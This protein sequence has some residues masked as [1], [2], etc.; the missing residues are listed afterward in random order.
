MFV[1][2]LTMAGGY[3]FRGALVQVFGRIISP[4][5]GEDICDRF[6]PQFD[7]S[8]AYVSRNAGSSWQTAST[9]SD[10]CTFM[11]QMDDI[12]EDAPIKLAIALANEVYQVWEIWAD[13]TELVEETTIPF[14]FEISVSDSVPFWDQGRSLSIHYEEVSLY[15]L[16]I[17][18]LVLLIAQTFV[19]LRIA[20]LM[21]DIRVINERSY[22]AVQKSQR[23]SVE[24]SE[25]PGGPLGW[26]A[27]H[28]QQGFGVF[29]TFDQAALFVLDHYPLVYAVATEGYSFVVS[30]HNKK[31]LLKK[32][33]LSNPSKSRTSRLTKLTEDRLAYDVVLKGEVVRLS[34][35]WSSETFDIEA[36]LFAKALDFHWGQPDFLYFYMLKR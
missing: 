8:E 11:L 29:L 23:L 31:E 13:G 18:I 6:E 4:E 22:F 19:S 14:K 32:L 15:F 10:S 20:R 27:N 5:T 9:G 2:A 33:A 1:V 30:P 25:L 36:G 34:L 28:I 16:A 21:D 7:I 24:L 26:L 3:F 17:L 35:G 12:S